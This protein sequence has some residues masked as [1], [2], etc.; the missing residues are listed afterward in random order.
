MA[1]LP[2][3]D[4][5]DPVDA[6]KP[7]R[8][9]RMTAGVFEL[10]SIFKSFTFAMAFD[11]GAV[12]MND[13]ID[14]RSAIRVGGFTINDFHGK[15]RVLTVPEV[16]IYSSNIG[17]A[18]HGAEGRRRGAAGL[19]QA[20]RLLRAAEDRYCPRSASRSSPRSGRT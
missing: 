2:D 5:N 11:S 4:P 10:G 7:D 14:A 8:L 3:Y 9:N 12:T 15:H 18:R 17:T 16:F 20:L 6:L 19:S 1:S 13:S